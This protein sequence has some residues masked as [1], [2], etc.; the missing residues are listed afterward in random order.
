MVS[1]MGGLEHIFLDQQV[2]GRSRTVW[3]SRHNKKVC[4]CIGGSA[5]GVRI[6]SR[7]RTVLSYAKPLQPNS[8]E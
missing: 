4:S 1:M 3:L 7:F 8:L 5:K 2:G 6:L